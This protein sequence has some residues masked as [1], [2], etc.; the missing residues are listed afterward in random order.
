MA[1][2]AVLA[3]VVIAIAV[4]EVGGGPVETSNSPGAGLVM[5]TANGRA[6]NFAV[7][8]QGGS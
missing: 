2:T 6:L 5:S 4:P 8:S 1:P 3:G 7:H